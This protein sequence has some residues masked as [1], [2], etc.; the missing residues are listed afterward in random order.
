[1]FMDN[2]INEIK[3][4][5][6]ANLCKA[7]KESVGIKKSVDFL[8]INQDCL[9]TLKENTIGVVISTASEML[10]N[11]MRKAKLRQALMVPILIVD[12]A[13]QAGATEPPMMIIE[14]S[15]FNSEKEL[16]DFLG[17]IIDSLLYVDTFDFGFMFNEAGRL[18]FTYVEGENLEI[19]ADKLRD[20]L[21]HH[22]DICAKGSVVLATYNIA[23]ADSFDVEKFTSWTK[24][25]HKLFG[26][27]CNFIDDVRDSSSENSSV[28]VWVKL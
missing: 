11:T 16:C 4:L 17:R 9:P 20:S 12:E 24:G 25:V 14:K 18:F 2:D 7:V 22:D 28:S 15:R 26:E 5:C 21:K 1:M 6:D 23:N 13:E 3:V 10:A 8:D 27:S 19:I